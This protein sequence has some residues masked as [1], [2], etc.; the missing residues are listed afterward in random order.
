MTQFYGIK[1]CY[2]VV[3]RLEA[4]HNNKRLSCCRGTARRC[5]HQLKSCQLLYEKLHLKTLQW[6]NDLLLS[7]WRAKPVRHCA[8]LLCPILHFQRSREISAA[9]LSRPA[10]MLE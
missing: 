3:T 4:A 10:V 6:G 5:K 7:S 1:F 9:R 8:V 2:G